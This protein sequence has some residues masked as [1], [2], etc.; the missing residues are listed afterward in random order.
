MANRVDMAGQSPL[1]A[2]GVGGFST[3][4]DV[5][6]ARGIRLEEKPARAAVLV[7]ARRGKA[8]EVKCAVAAEFGVELPARP[9]IVYGK[10]MDALWSG[11]SQWLLTADTHDAGAIIA[12]LEHVLKGLAS[13]TDQSDA[14]I[15]VRITGARVRDALAKVLGIDLDDAVFPTGCA[16][17]TGLAHIPVHVW[18][19]ADDD[20]HAA[21]ALSA[22]RSYA[23]SF[24]HHLVAAASE[25]GLEARTAGD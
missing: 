23:G 11:P 17:T 5:G 13:V 22:P 2:A 19:S 21:F 14:R 9:A 1:R 15:E 10:Q 7:V 8:A 12:R 4:A 20:G 6:G 3:M 25:F 24:W 18:R 16:A